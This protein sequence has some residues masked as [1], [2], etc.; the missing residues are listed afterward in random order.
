LIS[1]PAAVAYFAP[2]ATNNFATST[3]TYG[4]NQVLLP[5]QVS[6]PLVVRV[7][8]Q[9]GLPISGIGVNFGSNGVGT[10]N[11]VNT[12]TG[13]DGYAETIYTAGSAP[14]DLGLISILATAGNLQA[15]LSVGVGT[16][17]LAT[18]TTLSVV[19]GQGQV[20]LQDPTGGPS[21]TPL[22]FVVQATNADGSAAANAAITFTL[23][24]GTG[25]LFAPDG[26]T[27]TSIVV[28]TGVTGQAQAE[29]VPPIVPYYHGF[30]PAT[31]TAS[32]VSNPSATPPTVISTDFYI[33]TV[34]LDIQ[35]C[36]TPP[37]PPV[38]PIF[39]QVL[40]PA[41]GTVLTGPASSTLT[42]AAQV[43]VTAANGVPIPNVGVQA[44][45]GTNPN[46]P[47][48]SCSSAA[49]GGVALTNTQGIATCDVLLNGVPGTKP[50][51]FSLQVEGT[52][53][54]GISFGGYTLTIV[55]GAPANVTKISGDNQTLPAGSFLPQPFVIKV[56]DAHNNPLPNTPVTWTVPSGGFNVTSYSTVTGA[57]GEAS[58]SGFLFANGGSTVTVQAT[59]GTASATFTVLS[60]VAA[61]TIVIASGNNQSAQVNTPFP[62][63]LVVH[64]ADKFGH[65]ASFATVGFTT[66]GTARLSSNV[67]IA[68]VNGQ[69]SVTVTSAG[70]VAGPLTVTA[71]YGAGTAA[72]TV[73]FSLTVTA[74][75][76]VGP[77]VLNS[78]SLAPGLSPGGLVSFMGSGLAPTITGVVTDPTQFSGYSDTFDGNPAPI[79][80]IINQNGS[81]QINAQVPFEEP[82]TTTATVAIQTPTGSATL[83]NVVV[84]TFAPGIFTNGTIASS[85]QNYPLAT[86]IRPDGSYVSASNPAMRGE[87]IMFFA[88]GLG[89]TNPPASTGVPGV[90]GQLV[91]SPLYSGVNNQGSAVISAVYQPGSIGVY[92]ITIQIPTSTVPGPAQPLSLFMVD[93]TGTGYNAPAAFLPIQ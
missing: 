80:A 49:G 12:A 71:A 93:I 24:S 64:L 41:S 5:G 52:P 70:P 21:G 74:L 54:T 91:G 34:P 35:Y 10:V 27:Q 43:L 16:T 60:S 86:A 63:P 90:P 26:S 53:G 3:L 39:G 38:V 61:A 76:P 82:P 18:P 13:K 32:A 81:E 6:L 77:E 40:S 19:S 72:I 59:A 78:A 92:N 88:T 47:N 8:D 66:S 9:N 7:L 79:L 45:T 84:A 33:N 2:T 50:L 14:N 17:L 62:N 51:F 22:P 85:G 69:A 30:Q 31:I 89:Q 73:K 44:T 42:G 68:D 36:G 4:N 28:P 15:S 37:C 56:T 57:T 20:I 87:N 25:G 83:S 65:P 67:V 55:P 75:G 23:T 48:A 29:Y 1:F 46:V 11:P 58:A